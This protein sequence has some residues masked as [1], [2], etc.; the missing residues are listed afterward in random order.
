MLRTMPADRPVSAHRGAS[1]LRR[2]LLGTATVAVLLFAAACSD[3]AQARIEANPGW[4]IDEPGAQVSICPS[5]SEHRLD[6]ASLRGPH[7]GLEVECVAS[8]AEFPEEYQIRYLTGEM[9]LYPPPE[10]YEY[11][12]IQF[13]HE[14][15]LS[16]VEEDDPGP[17]DTVLTVDD[18]EWQME[19]VPEPGSAYMVVAPSSPDVSLDVTDT[20]LAQSLDLNTGERGETVDALYTG[21]LTSIETGSTTGEVEAS[22][23]AW[24][25]NANYG[26]NFDVTRSVYYDG[27][28][29]DDNSEAVLIVAYAWSDTFTTGDVTWDLDP[30]D[31]LSVSQGGDSLSAEDV[32]TYEIDDGD[33]SGEGIEQVFYVDGSELEFEL[34]FELD[35]QFTIEDENATLDVNDPPTE[36]FSVDFS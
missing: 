7:F 36:T 23:S 33:L 19:G 10:G 16:A 32:N 15:E 17:V 31:A 25:V 5:E 29:V 21:Q 1:G 8:M 13:S 12:F 24:E 18:Y 2:Y 20:G 26:L 34:E 11:T 9:D 27:E 4:Q 30:V 22:S 14:P 28:W 35:G 3:P 6:S